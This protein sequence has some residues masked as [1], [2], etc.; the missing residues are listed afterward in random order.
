MDDTGEKSLQEIADEMA[1]AGEKTL[2]DA[3]NELGEEEAKVA[4]VQT[5]L[6]SVSSVDETEGTV[7][8]YFRGELHKV[9]A[10]ESDRVSVW[11]DGKA[12]NGKKSWRKLWSTKRERRSE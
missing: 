2:Q 12:A 1:S 8:I 7:Y 11:I 3:V 10:A 6:E 4:E 9:N 5:G